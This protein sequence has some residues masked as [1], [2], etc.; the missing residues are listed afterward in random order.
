M[1]VVDALLERERRRRNSTWSSR[2]SSWFLIRSRT[3]IASSG[4]TRKSFAPPAS[5]A[6][7][8][9]RV[10]SAV[11]TITGS[12]LALIHG[13]SCRITSK[14]SAAGMW[15]SSRTRSGGL[16]VQS[17]TPAPDSVVVA[18]FTY[19]ARSSRRSSN[20][21]L[22]GSSS[23]IRMRAR[24]ERLHRGGQTADL[25]LELGVE[26]AHE[27]V[28]VERLREEHLGTSCKQSLDARLRR[29]GAH[30]DHRYLRGERI[31]FQLAQ[32]VLAVHAGKVE[33]EQDQR[34]PVLP[35][36]LQ[37]QRAVHRGEQPDVWA[38]R[39]DALDEPQVRP[40]V[41]DVEHGLGLSCGAVRCSCGAACRRPARRSA[42]RP[43]PTRW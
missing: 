18:K 34:G 10:V 12:A 35:G 33:V 40:V 9:S 19:P 30:D 15:R 37:A 27:P 28:H 24:C 11:R 43:R 4:F 42:Q 25:L 32:H 21:T 17:G 3:S 36:E 41:L 31:C 26:E 5:A 8:T 7:R 22:A 1:L 6:C 23:T 20:S 39:Q 16:C 38:L 2:V 13:S 14:P 29:V